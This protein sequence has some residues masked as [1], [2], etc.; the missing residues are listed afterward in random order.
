V[1]LLSA[2]GIR[3]SFKREDGTSLEILRGIDLDLEAGE[4]VSIVGRS[5]SGKSTLLNIIGLL[6]KPTEGTVEFDGEDALRMRA[7]ARDRLRGSSIGFVF[8]QFNLLPG[9]TALENVEMPLLYES[10]LSFWR[11][12]R[13]ARETLELVGLG[14]RAGWKPAR[15]SG[16]EQQRVAIA[17]ALVRSP[18]LILADEPTGALDVDTGGAIMDLLERVSHETGATIVT[19]THDRLIAGRADRVVRVREGLLADDDPGED[20]VP[21]GDDDGRALVGVAASAGAGA[22]R[23]GD[24]AGSTAPDAAGPQRRFAAGNPFAPPTGPPPAA[25]APPAA[26]STSAASE[27]VDPR[28]EA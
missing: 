7:G 12:S 6:D 19:I 21:T 14:E 3:R 26:S 20:A 15:L 11:R 8:Q 25:S 23:I 28:A 9:R 1:S 4:R 16:G 5:G 22:D 2:R 24:G 10:G 13:I 27:P 17:R 18:K